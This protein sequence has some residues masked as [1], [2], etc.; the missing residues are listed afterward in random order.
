[1]HNI[2]WAVIFTNGTL[3][4][5]VLA[6]GVSLISGTRKKRKPAKL[7]AGDLVEIGF[8]ASGETRAGIITGAVPAP[9]GGFTIKCAART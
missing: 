7:F 1:M 4:L 5:V 8:V 3:C 6:I 9:D 2:H